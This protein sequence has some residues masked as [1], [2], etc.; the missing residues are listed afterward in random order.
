MEF[1]PGKFIL[2]KFLIRKIT[3]VKEIELE[4]EHINDKTILKA[5]IKDNIDK[6]I[7]NY[8]VG[9]KVFC[10]GKVSTSSQTHGSKYIE[11][12]YITK[13]LEEDVLS[14]SAKNET[15]TICLE[16]Y[17]QRFDEIVEGIKDVDYKSVIINCFNDDVKEL[18]FS[19]PAS[20]SHHHNY[21]HGLLQHS[22][23]VVD[24]CL[25][26]ADYFGDFNKDL[27]SCAGLIHD[28]GK[29]KSYDIED[30]KVIKSNWEC[31]LGHLPISSLFVSKIVPENIDSNKIMLLYH[32]ILS[33]HGRLEWHSP[34]V[35]KTKEAFILHQADLIS[36]SYKTINFLNYKNNWRIEDNTNKNEFSNKTWYK[37]S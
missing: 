4:L 13:N 27:L 19:Y 32:M 25:L 6:F 15:K 14:T 34:V 29:L 2:G 18:F 24:I 9:D 1:E 11:L 12:V 28:I 33:H 30:M 26:L 37:E 10:K 23:E 16:R 21:T 7:L 8:F 31:L 35:P 20:Q 3:I 36:S 22:I 17:I 5:I